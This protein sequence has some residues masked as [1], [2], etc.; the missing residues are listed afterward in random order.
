MYVRQ[1]SFQTFLWCWTLQ[2]IS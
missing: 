2:C 1:Q